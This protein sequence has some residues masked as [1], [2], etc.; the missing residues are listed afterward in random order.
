MNRKDCCLAAA[1]GLALLGL[2]GSALGLFVQ[3]YPVD[4][5]AETL[6]LAFREAHGFALSRQVPVLPLLLHDRAGRLTVAYAAKV[7]RLE[8]SLEAGTV[9]GRLEPAWELLRK[10][11]LAGDLEKGALVA[12]LGASE[13]RPG[14]P[15]VEVVVLTQTPRGFALLTRGIHQTE[16]VR[17]QP[18]VEGYLVVSGTECPAAPYPPDGSLFSLEGYRIPARF[19]IAPYPPGSSFLPLCFG[20]GGGLESS[21][22]YAFPPCLGL[23]IEDEQ[24]GQMRMLKFESSSGKSRILKHYGM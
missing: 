10:E 15:G 9:A 24:T 3:T 12:L 18:G 11:R 5:A 23:T 22:A 7:L 6:A 21:A 19:G 2:M 4:A 14:E 13:L 1:L 17:I 8:G 20:T 16:P